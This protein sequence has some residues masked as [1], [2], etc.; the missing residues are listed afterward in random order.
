VKIACDREDVEFML[1]AATVLWKLF[2][3][4]IKKIIYLALLPASI[5][6]KMLKTK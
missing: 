3:F 5:K 4:L 1:V 2:N 6:A